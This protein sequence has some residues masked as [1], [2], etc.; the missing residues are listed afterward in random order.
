MK[1]L[2]IQSDGLLA[3]HTLTKWLAI[4]GEGGIIPVIHA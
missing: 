4:L 3:N 1:S 2:K